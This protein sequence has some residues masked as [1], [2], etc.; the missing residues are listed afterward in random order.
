M[1]KYKDALIQ[2]LNAQEPEETIEGEGGET[3]GLY[4]VATE[5]IAGAILCEDSD[6]SV[7][8]TFYADEEELTEAWDAL[9]AE[10]EE[11]EDS[12]EDEEDEEE[13]EDE[14]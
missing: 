7:S 10:D 9:S 12:E 5:D 13:P 8:A 6:G 14:D 2:E 11:D 1:T 4:R 3:F